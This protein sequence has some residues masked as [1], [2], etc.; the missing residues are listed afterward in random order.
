M[1]TTDVV[2]AVF[3]RASSQETSPQVQDF[4]LSAL[5]AFLGRLLK[6]ITGL[7]IPDLKPKAPSARATY[8]AA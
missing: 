8:R 5:R 2:L 3:K 7:I 4:S 6:K 1:T